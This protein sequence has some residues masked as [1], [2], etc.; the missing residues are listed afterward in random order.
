MRKPFN[1]L[2]SCAPSRSDLAFL[3]GRFGSFHSF[4]GFDE[5]KLILHLLKKSQK[6]QEDQKSQIEKL[7]KTFNV[8]CEIFFAPAPTNFT[9]FDLLFIPSNESNI[10]AKKDLAKSQKIPF[11]AH[12]KEATLR[13]IL[14]F[15]RD[16]AMNLTDYLASFCAKYSKK[17][18][19]KICILRPD[20]IGDFVLFANFL[21][22]LNTHFGEVTLI[23]NQAFG[24]LIIPFSNYISKNITLNRKKFLQNIIYRFKFIYKL[25]K[26]HFELFINPLFSRDL[27]SE[28]VA[29]NVISDVKI[30]QTGN[31]IN[32]DFKKLKQFNKNYSF[33]IKSED[34]IIFEFYR[35]KIFFEKLL[36]KP[37]YPKLEIDVSRKNMPHEFGD[38]KNPFV[39]FIGASSALRKWAFFG[40]I[41][42][43]L[44]QNGFDIAICGGKEDAKRADEILK[45]TEKTAQKYARSVMNL[46]AKTTLM[47]LAK[48]LQN[49][50]VLTNETG[51]AHIAKAVQ[52]KQIYVIYNGNNAKRFAPYPDTLNPKSKYCL[53]KHEV[54]EWDFDRYAVFSN[55]LFANLQINEISP[56]LVIK[57]IKLS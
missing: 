13:R 54:M 51:A 11:F 56:D 8:N 37:L 40:D 3:L 52:S 16:F 9:N 41:A 22:H 26:M 57:A 55:H 47:D 2:F 36:K 7:A 28:S 33:I 39:L 4:N 29:K 27:L 6:E 19:Q 53:I 35:N 48:I 1:I 42:E 18:S 50:P 32:L 38:L 30:A 49:A 31:C 10:K 14:K 21:E 43:F 20:G 44:L 17:S 5:I 25:K 46:C 45:N 24:D 23:S 15:L 34:D 12:K